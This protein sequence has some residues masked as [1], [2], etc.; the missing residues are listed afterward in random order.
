MEPGSS[1]RSSSI[2]RL[3]SSD[4]IKYSIAKSSKSLCY[5]RRATTL[6]PSPDDMT[7]LAT[8]SLLTYGRETPRKVISTD[9]TR[10]NVSRKHWKH[11]WKYP[12]ICSR[13]WIQ[14]DMCLFS[15]QA[16]RSGKVWGV[17]V[18]GTLVCP[19]KISQEIVPG[20]VGVSSGTRQVVG[21]GKVRRKCAQW[22]LASVEKFPRDWCTQGDIRPF[23]KQAC[24]WKWSE[25]YVSREYLDGI[26]PGHPGPGNVSRKTC[27]LLTYSGRSPWGNSTLEPVG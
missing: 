9:S 22:I 15:K 21:S 23:S 27:S 1:C 13:K 6:R 12:E 3:R 18:L 10:G 5:D 11:S 20:N 26:H 2:D 19:R 8:S 24:R 4:P 7:T 17:C 16:F 25:R 14:G